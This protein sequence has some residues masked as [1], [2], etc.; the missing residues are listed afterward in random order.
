MKFASEVPSF[1]NGGRKVALCQCLMKYSSPTGDP[2]A[3]CYFPGTSIQPK[4]C[5][6]RGERLL[7]QQMRSAE[8]PGAAR[9]RLESPGCADCGGVTGGL[10][11]EVLG[12]RRASLAPETCP[13][14]RFSSGS[15]PNQACPRP[16]AARPVAWETWRFE[17]GGLHVPSLSP[18][19]AVPGA[20]A[21]RGRPKA[22]PRPTGPC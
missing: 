21:P 7:P 16:G 20:A 18:G 3:E 11:Q 4:A 10:R 14:H 22:S 1:V 8:L 5:P 17:G 13:C 6:G 9:R 12:G 2:Q 19:W 15:T